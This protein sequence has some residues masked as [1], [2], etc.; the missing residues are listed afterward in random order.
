MFF[1]TGV[2]HSAVTPR[3]ASSSSCSRQALEVAAVEGA[4]GVAVHRRRCWRGRRPRSDRRRRS[5]GPRPPSG[6]GATLG[7]ADGAGCG[8]RPPSRVRGRGWPEPPS[9]ARRAAS[10]RP[11]V[12]VASEWGPWRTPPDTGRQVPGASGATDCGG[13]QRSVV[14]RGDVGT[15]GRGTVSNSLEMREGASEQSADGATRHVPDV[16]LCTSV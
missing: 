9:R 8:A 4:L 12:R 5:R 1:T 15:S 10:R 13:R 3:E 6:A 2:I 14:G 16:F 11:P 7:A